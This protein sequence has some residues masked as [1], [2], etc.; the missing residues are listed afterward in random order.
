MFELSLNHIMKYMGTH[1]LFEDL[2]FQVFS[3]ERVGIVGENGCGKSTVL[4]LIAGLIPLNIYIGSWSLGYDKG[5]IYKPKDARIAYLDQMPKYPSHFTVKDVL[6]DAFKD[7]LDLEHELR[8]L[9]QEMAHEEGTSLEKHLD[10]YARLTLEFETKG[11]YEV[12]EKYQKICSGLQ[13]EDN[14]LEKPF[15]ML[16]GGEQTTVVL[17]K[18]L[19]DKPDIL[20]L[21]EPTNHLD[22]DAIEWLEN[23]LSEYEGILIVVSHDRY[24][25]DKVVTKVVEIEDKNAQTF[26]GNYSSYV[27]Q[28]EEQVRIQYEDYMLQKKEKQLME[29]KVKQLREWAIRADNNKFFRRAASIQIKMDKMEAIKRPA[30]NKANMKLDLKTTSRTGEETIVIKNLC[31]AYDDQTLFKQADL[32]VR[33][34]ERLAL[35]G[36]NGSGKTT[37]VKMLLGL[38]SADSGDLKVANNAKI[39]YLPQVIAFENENLEVIDCFREGRDIS[40]GKAREYLSKFM[41]FG[42]RVFT[43]V[44]ALSG[45]ERIRLK[46]AMLLYEEANVLIL[47]EP[48]N[49]L[50]IES[51]ETLETA[52]LEFK[53]T[54]FFIS[55]DR[56]FINEVCSGVVAV[57]EGGL[58]RYDGNYDLYRLRKPSCEPI[59][60]NVKKASEKTGGDKP[61]KENTKPKSTSQNPLKLKVIT[62]KIQMLE[63]QLEAIEKAIE[64]NQTDYLKL[65]ILIQEKEGLDSELAKLL[66]KWVEM[67]AQG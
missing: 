5:Y 40:E 3:G 23:Y 37:L 4:K 54:L 27:A 41:F 2:S 47:D 33:Y 25:L 58:N 30:I 67:E 22:T 6:R 34:G 62:D 42:K 31:K 65:D 53:G 45:G 50:D 26:N 48:T 35:V 52:L 36:G 64:E 44:S 46:L 55:H 17:G 19:L 11:G 49:H 28:K 57:E 16:S 56:Y 10:K 12:E 60:V 21:D 29:D 7:V 61:L 14:F 18:I 15:E 66:E 63:D 24:F 9:E 8:T 43:D 59:K 32:V 20:L 39:A 1:L 51:I 38:E 13:F